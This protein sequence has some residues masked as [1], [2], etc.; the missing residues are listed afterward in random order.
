MP[1]RYQ[2]NIGLKEDDEM[3]NIPHVCTLSGAVRIIDVEYYYN[4][5]PNEI[6]HDLC[7]IGE[8]N[9]TCQGCLKMDDWIF[10]WFESEKEIEEF[11]KFDS[12]NEFTVLSYE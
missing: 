8:F 4:D 6:R 2:L 7:A 10:Y 11:K 3:K 9:D 1:I 12:N 5:K